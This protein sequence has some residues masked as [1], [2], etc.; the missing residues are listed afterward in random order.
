ML[1]S[2]VAWV[3]AIASVSKMPSANRLMAFAI[4]ST[5]VTSVAVKSTVAP[6]TEEASDTWE[7]IVFRTLF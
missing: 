1:M 6:V 3:A 2:F 4:T 5:V 7:S